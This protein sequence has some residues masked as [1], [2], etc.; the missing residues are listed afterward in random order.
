[1]TFSFFVLTHTRDKIGSNS[2]T[3]QYFAYLITS[4]KRTYQKL[5]ESLKNDFF[6]F[7]YSLT[8]EIKQALTQELFN[9][10]KI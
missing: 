7:S 4:H 8:L 1:M 2:G 9:N 5:S 6:V 10:S 3:I